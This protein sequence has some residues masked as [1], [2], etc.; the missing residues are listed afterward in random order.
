MGAL[1]TP[2]TDADVDDLVGAVA[3]RIRSMQ[4]VAVA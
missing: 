2:T 4:A 1:A 3:A